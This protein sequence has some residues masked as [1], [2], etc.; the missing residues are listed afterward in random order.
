MTEN[1]KVIDYIIKDMVKDY[2]KFIESGEFKK[3]SDEE[4]DFAVDLFKSHAKR[5]GYKLVSKNG[6]L[7]MEQDMSIKPETTITFS[8][9]LKQVNDKKTK[10]QF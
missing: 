8:Q 10:E 6:K 4:K 2:G 5:M 9:I 7:C 3:L 1:K